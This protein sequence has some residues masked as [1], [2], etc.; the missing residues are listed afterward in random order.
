MDGMFEPASGRGALVG[1]ALP[2]Q[3]GALV[4]AATRVF[5]EAELDG[6]AARAGWDCWLGELSRALAPFAAVRV[7]PEAVSA[8]A[9][10]IAGLISLAAACE[11]VMA[12]PRRVEPIGGQRISYVPMGEVIDALRELPAAPLTTN[13]E[14]ELIAMAAAS[15]RQAAESVDASNA[16]LQRV[17]GERDQ[18]A[19]AL[20]EIAGEFPDLLVFPAVAAKAALTRLRL[21]DLKVTS[22]AEAVDGATREI[23]AAKRKR[24]GR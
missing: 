6:L 4:E 24:D 5:A 22:M 12:I 11:A 19:V 8:T 23:L 14:A 3:I 16:E 17:T 20:G 21:G 2:E 9:P 15:L 10:V 7:T 18:L 13:S 1:A